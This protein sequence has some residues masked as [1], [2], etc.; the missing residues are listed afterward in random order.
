MTATEVMLSQYLETERK[1]EG[2]WFAL[3]GGELIALADTNEEL[4]GKLREIGARDV[5][6]G[7]A[8]T[9]AEREAGCL[10]VIFH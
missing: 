10:Y 2:K 6:I 1:F 5:L 7:H 4:R 8:S 3:K 9:K